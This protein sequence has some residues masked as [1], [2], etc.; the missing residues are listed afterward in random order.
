MKGIY[1]SK[2]KDMFMVRHYV[3]FVDGKTKHVYVG[4]AKTIEAARAIYAAYLKELL[5]TTP[6]AIE[7]A[8]DLEAI[9]ELLATA[10][11]QKVRG[12]YQKLRDVLYESYLAASSVEVSNV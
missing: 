11:S 4:R 10:Q 12:C 1:Y 3:G 8:A 7:L 9:D 6:R 2:P 5:P